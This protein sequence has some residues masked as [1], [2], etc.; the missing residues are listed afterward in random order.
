MPLFLSSLVHT[1]T[2]RRLAMQ[3]NKQHHALLCMSAE[4]DEVMDTLTYLG[5]HDYTT[6]Q[7]DDEIMIIIND[8]KERSHL[9]LNSITTP[10]SMLPTW[11]HPE[12]VM[13][14]QGM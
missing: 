11:V 2:Q 4:M 12:N 3:Y 9:Y 6:M 1:Y 5:E 7:H 10:M 8:I 13:R 14:G